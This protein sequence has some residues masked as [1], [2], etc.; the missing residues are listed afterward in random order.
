MAVYVTLAISVKRRNDLESSDFELLWVE[1]KALII[2]FVVYVID[3]PA[4]IPMPILFSLRICSPVWIKL[5]LL[6]LTHLLFLLVI[7][8]LIMI[9]QI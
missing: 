1:L 8:M 9:L 6:K 5:I 2:C 7:S 4:V 3:H